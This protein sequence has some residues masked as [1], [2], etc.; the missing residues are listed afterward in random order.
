MQKI[1]FTTED[2]LLNLLKFL[3]IIVLLPKTVQFA[4]YLSVLLLL[5]FKNKVSLNNSVILLICG[6]FIQMLAILW[7][8]IV[9]DP[10]MVRIAA[11]VNTL[12]IWVVSILLYSVACNIN[13]DRKTIQKAAKYARINLMILFL[14]YCFSLVYTRN[15]IRILGDTFYLKRM[16]YLASGIT[17]RFCGLLE[18]VIGPSHMFFVSAPMLM[19]DNDT[20]E[21]ALRN[22]VVLFLAYIAIVATH[23]RI[24]LVS[25]GLF[26][27]YYA[28]DYI[29][30]YFT[31]SQKAVLGFALAVTAAFLFLKYRH[32]IAFEF[33]SLF[34]ARGG[35]NSARF[36]IYRNS[37][38][39]MWQESPIIGI[40]I[41]YML[42]SFPYGSHSTYVGLLYKAGFLGATFYFSGLIGMV[43][44]MMNSIK[45]NGWETAFLMAIICY[46][47]LMIFSDIDGSDWSIASLFLVY[48]IVTKRKE[49]TECLKEKTLLRT[50]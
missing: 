10:A 15:T 49:R 6:C 42:G 22:G 26:V 12:L 2:I 13:K 48:G 50:A 25:C 4:V 30:R 36:G 9:N 27:A 7:Q 17:T 34:N 45:G 14:L 1:R 33:N 11:A 3:W 41:K 5:L 19:L 40:G 47:V 38:R 21:K 39:K 18:T 16:D 37:L 24:G 35:S 46:A 8:F 44:R 32:Y 20:K 28:L 31:S 29:S 43:K 23:S